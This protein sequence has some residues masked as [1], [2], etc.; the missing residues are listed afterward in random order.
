MH[1]LRWSILRSGVQ[2]SVIICCG[3][4]SLSSYCFYVFLRPL[5]AS[6]MS[7]GWLVTHYITICWL[8]GLSFTKLVTAI[9]VIDDKEWVKS[10]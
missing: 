10:G 6:S 5:C 9:N 1:R 3:P 7:I 8:V 2:V 4:I